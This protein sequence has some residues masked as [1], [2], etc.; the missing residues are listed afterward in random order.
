MPRSLVLLLVPVLGCAAP[1]VDESPA[2][3]PRPWS[4][5]PPLRDAERARLPGLIEQ[6]AAADPDVRAEGEARLLALGPGAMLALEAQRERLHPQAWASL[7]R[8]AERILAFNADPPL[9]LWAERWLIDPCGAKLKVEIDQPY[10]RMLEVRYTLFD[11]QGGQ[12][13]S[14]SGGYMMMARGRV[15]HDDGHLLRCYDLSTGRWWEAP[16]LLPSVVW[17]QRTAPPF[18]HVGEDAVTLY[19]RRTLRSPRNGIQPGRFHVVE[20]YRLE[21]GALLFREVERVA[22]EASR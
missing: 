8:V 3:L 14:R 2:L 1:A 4:L 19:R 9:G 12:R 10:F 6:L 15:V 21:D 13:W 16:N 5:A 18:I 7:E 11:G 17:Q 20:R 22:E